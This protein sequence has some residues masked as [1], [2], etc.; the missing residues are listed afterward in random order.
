MAGLSKERKTYRG[1]CHCGANVFEMKVPEITKVT[2]C[3]C[4]ICHRNATIWQTLKEGDTLDWVK[5]GP[6]TMKVYKF[7]SKMFEHQFCGNCGDS[8]MFSGK[9]GEGAPPMIGLN[10]RCVPFHTEKEL[11]R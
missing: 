7:A 3:N 11:G 1:N 9:F 8:V 6:E 2:V 5:G 4:S 10:V